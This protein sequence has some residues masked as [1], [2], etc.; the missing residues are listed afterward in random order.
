MNE[1]VVVRVSRGYGIVKYMCFV[2]GDCWLFLGFVK[3]ILVEG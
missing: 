2:V 3:E 1:L